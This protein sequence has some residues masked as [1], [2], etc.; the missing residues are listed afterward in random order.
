MAIYLTELDPEIM[1]FPSPFEALED[2]N[3]LLAFGGDLSVQ[4]LLTAYHNGIF[5]WYGPDEP[6]LWWS[7]SPRAVF[8]PLT[9]RASKSVKKFQRKHQYQI[10]INQATDQVIDYCASTRSA[11]ETWLSED[12]RAAYKQLAKQ[13]Y[14][15]SVEVWQ[16]NLLIGGLYG[17]SVGQLF[18]GESMFSLQTNA[19]KIALWYFCSHF[20]Q[21]GGK[22]IDCQVLNDHTQSLGAFELEREAFI[23]SLLSLR[24][25][26]INSQCFQPQWLAL[27]VEERQ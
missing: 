16:Q 18:C 26:E 25:Q 17:I 14:C 12:M 15:H 7:P 4:R 9:F 27:P 24:Q 10:S 19:S 23:K 20:K 5:P 8:D 3:G 13:G 2:P 6:I 22:L 1:S 11:E 21:H